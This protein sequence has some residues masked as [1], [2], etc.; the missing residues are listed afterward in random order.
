MVIHNVCQVI[1]RKFVSPLPEH[2]VIQGI[3]IYLDVTAD[4]VVHFH[5][6]IVRHLEADGPAVCGL[7]QFLYLILRESKG[8]AKLHPC[9]LIVNKSL[10][11]SLG[12]S[13]FRVKFLSRIEGIVCVTI[14]DKL[15]S[16][17]AVNAFSL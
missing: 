11:G 13:A 12:L 6:R 8:I 3:S 2:L 5:D 15:V 7:Q 16:E 17:L 10:S 4:E 1:C 14:L 9:F